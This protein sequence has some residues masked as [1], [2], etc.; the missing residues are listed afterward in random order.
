MPSTLSLSIVITKSMGLVQGIK[1][2]AVSYS[3]LQEA[4]G[5]LGFALQYHLPSL[6]AIGDVLNTEPVSD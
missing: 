6:T 1:P 2:W 4:R 5:L 3:Y